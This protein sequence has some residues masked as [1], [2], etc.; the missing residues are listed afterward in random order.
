MSWP[1]LHAAAARDEA[2]RVPFVLA[3][4]RVGSVARRHLPLL[5]VHAPWIE[6]HE[7]AVVCARI[8]EAAFA[9]LHLRLRDA[10]AILA[11]RDELFALF[12]PATL[13]P[14]VAIERAAARF[15]GT[16]TLGA[17]ANGFVRGDHDE[18]GRPSHLWIARRSPHKATDPGLLDN[19]VGGGV[20]ADQTPRQTLVREGLEEA[21]LE[22]A[23]MAAAVPASVLRLHRDIREGLQHEWLYGFDL[24]LP[25]G[26]VPRNH[27]GE[28]AE[29]AL[30]PLAEVVQLLRDGEAM[31]TDAALVTLDFLLRHGLLGDEQVA[32]QLVAL[33]V[34][35][36]SR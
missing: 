9:A 25:P 36:P 29:F 5:A 15:W 32:A 11:W 16:L 3:G 19:L 26:V 28:V 34:P 20:P 18:G 7:G 27:D 30:R 24:E 4:R 8:D 2:A 23:Q 33:R 22:P 35:T 1:A 21:G 13:E 10:G 6:Q 12:D 31:T 14:L 17:H